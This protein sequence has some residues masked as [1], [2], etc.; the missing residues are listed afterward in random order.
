MA[1]VGDGA[2]QSVARN[3][4]EENLH[5]SKHQLRA[6]S[7]AAATHTRQLDCGIFTGEHPGRFTN[8]MWGVELTGT[9]PQD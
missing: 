3:V 1:C 4:L 9:L 7:E 8:K 2:S 5:V 6:L